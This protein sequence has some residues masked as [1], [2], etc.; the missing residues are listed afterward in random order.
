MKSIFIKVF[1]ELPENLTNVRIP[2]F[3]DYLRI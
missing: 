2:E 3:K 1:N